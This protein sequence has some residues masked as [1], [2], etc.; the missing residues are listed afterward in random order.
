[1]QDEEPVVRNILNPTAMA[2]MEVPRLGS[3]LSHSSC[4]CRAREVPRTFSLKL[5][6]D[7]CIH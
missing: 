2:Q 4:G 6:T 5:V 1:M 7:K 3:P